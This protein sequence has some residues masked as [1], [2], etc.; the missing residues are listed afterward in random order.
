MDRLTVDTS[1]GDVTSVSIS[2]ETYTSRAK[3]QIT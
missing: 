2:T 1:L 3:K